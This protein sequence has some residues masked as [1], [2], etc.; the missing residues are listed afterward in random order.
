MGCTNEKAGKTTEEK[1]IF[2]ENLSENL[3]LPPNLAWHK[4][5]QKLQ[6]WICSLMREYEAANS[7]LQPL[8]K[9]TIFAAAHSFFREKNP[10]FAQL[11]APREAEAN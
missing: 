7:V 3:C 2:Y 4:L 9:L 10:L 1:F 5:F 11:N 6:Q 8:T